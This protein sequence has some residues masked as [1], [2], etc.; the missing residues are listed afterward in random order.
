MLNRPTI[1]MTDKT[2]LSKPLAEALSGFE[3]EYIGARNL[4]DR[5]RIASGKD[6]QDSL[7]YLEKSGVNDPKEVSPSDVHRKSLSGL[8]AAP[9]N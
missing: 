9:S 8:G 4:G 1:L 6:A 3:S 2:K 7:E 5:S